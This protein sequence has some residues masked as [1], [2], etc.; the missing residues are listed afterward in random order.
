M[1]D[2]L[3]SIPYPSFTHFPTPPMV[4]ERLNPNSHFGLGV[5]LFRVEWT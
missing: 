3:I 2:L 1:N 5:R 4:K